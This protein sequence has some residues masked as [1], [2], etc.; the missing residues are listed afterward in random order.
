MKEANST[1]K[2]NNVLNIKWNAIDA[3]ISLAF[4]TVALVGIYFG[5]AKLFEVLDGEQFFNSS[6]ISNASFT[7]LYGI[8]TALMLAVVWFFAIF[9]RKSNLRDL[10]L[11]YYSIAKTIWY[12][13]LSLLAIFFVSFLYMFLMNSLFGIENPGSKIEIL[14][15]NRSISSN[16]LLVVVA[17]I[18]PFSEEVFFRGFLYSAF[19]KSW[20]VN[21]ALLLSSFLFAIVH[22]ELYSFIPLIIIGWLLAY[23]FEKTKSLLMPIF[24]HGVY[25]LILILI[26]LG[27]LEIIKMY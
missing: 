2:Q 14:V 10:G 17:V 18:A 11:R 3:V 6:N 20:G 22:L 23:L 13:F 16:I 4:L 19:K 21:V 9:R 8:Q 5:S 27:R 15:G 25:N 12:S 26:L 24:L 1:E 7:V